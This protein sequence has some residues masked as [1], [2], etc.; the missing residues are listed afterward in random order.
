MNAI[1]A[2]NKEIGILSSRIA[3]YDGELRDIEVRSG[4][5]KSDDDA[6]QL[7]SARSRTLRHRSDLVQ[8]RRTLLN[9]KKELKRQL[10]GDGA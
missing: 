3:Q 1:S 4:S 2:I 5:I 8:K 7:G 9:K 10:K 6:R